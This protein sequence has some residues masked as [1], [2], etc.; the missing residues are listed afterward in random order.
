MAAVVPSRRYEVL[1]RIAVGGMAEIFLARVH[2]P[3]GFEKL[4]VL[5]RP[6]P[7][8]A[9]DREFTR[10]FLDEARLAATLDHPNIA[11]V[12]DF[13]FAE[14]RWFYAM[15]YVHGEDLRGVLNRAHRVLG[16]LPLHVALAIEAGI[17]QGLHYAHEKRGPEGGPL[18]LVHRDVS[19][20]N[21]LVSYDGSVKVVDFGIAK[22]QNLPST[23][24]GGGLKG[25]L[26]YMAPEQLRGEEIDRRV[27]VF[28]AGILL[29][30]MTTGARLFR[31]SAD[32]TISR[33]LTAEIVAPRSIIASYPEGL[34]RI[35]LRALERDRGA[36]Y[37]TAQD[38][39]IDL[40]QWA[41]RERR[42]M[43]AIAL[44]RFLSELFGTEIAAWQRAAETPESLAEHATQTLSD[45]SRGAPEPATTPEPSPGALALAG[46]VR[47]AKAGAR[48]R[49]EPPDVT[50]SEARSRATRSWWIVAVLA[51]IAAAAIGGA[52]LTGAGERDPT[53]AAPPAAATAPTEA[54]SQTIATPAAPA[55]TKARS[56]EPGSPPVASPE[57]AAAV[58]TPP[59]DRARRD[60]PGKRPPRAPR[61]RPGGTT[62]ADSALPW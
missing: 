42:T 58:L 59:A 7:Q 56:P 28:A 6:L 1:K 13:G 10:M 5:K 8:L 48:A 30:E 29:Y 17:L 4:V 36:R 55:G 9:A 47:A 52:A 20:S 44:Q 54:A 46:E 25:K 33:I 14:D 60:A 16:G 11:H 39:Q 21:V 22:A 43:S 3:E 53:P 35:V 41:L 15:E 61:E 31:G 2:G 51:A 34:E 27:D 62:G 49:A 24:G 26:A 57:P 40:E 18:G 45:R 38:M 12:Y 19:P 37:A 32:E 50:R 23:G